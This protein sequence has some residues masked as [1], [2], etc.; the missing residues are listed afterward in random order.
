MAIVTLNSPGTVMNGFTLCLWK[1]IGNSPT[2]I[3][4]TLLNDCKVLLPEKKRKEK[5]KSS[6]N[7]IT[8]HSALIQVTFWGF[9]CYCCFVVV[10]CFLAIGLS[11]NFFK[12]FNTNLCKNYSN[13]TREHAVKSKSPFSPWF[14]FMEATIANSFFCIVLEICHTNT[15]L[16]IC[17]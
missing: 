17:T 2:Q 13:S 10:F 16:S 9:F 5:T 6:R 11:Y 15:N 1:T 4:T 7:S 3:W 14:L 12:K 8:H